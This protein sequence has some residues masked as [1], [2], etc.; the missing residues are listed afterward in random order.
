M[1]H[2]GV[3]SLGNSLHVEELARVILDCSEADDG[4]GVSLLL[5]DLENL[6]GADGVLAGERVDAEEG[7]CRVVVEGSLRSESVL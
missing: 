2:L 3:T 1:T 5:D 7:G 6:L 4:D